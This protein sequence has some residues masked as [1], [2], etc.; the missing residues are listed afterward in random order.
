MNAA[1]SYWLSDYGTGHAWLKWPVRALSF[2]IFFVGWELV[3]RSEQYFAIVPVSET[4]DAL[5]TD[6]GEIWSAMLGTLRIAATGFVPA[7]VLGVLAGTL[8]GTSRI[9]RVALDPLVNVGVV[10]PMTMLVPVLGIYIGLGYRGKVTLV[11]L[12]SLF[13]IIINTAAGVAETPPALRETAHS[14]GIRGVALYRKVI[15]PGALPYVL[16]G[17]R[18][19]AGRA[20]QG[21]IIADLLLEVSHIGLYL[22]R[23][24]STF[25]MPALLAGTL[26]TVTVASAV[27]LL[28]RWAERRALRWLRP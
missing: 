12:F 4:F 18:L 23:A 26:F 6:R 19:G 15:L 16:T 21:A 7:A 8:I 27:M 14:F 3:G 13:V 2:A 1:S 25:D 17:L 5:W 10:A 11:L 9:G 28:A 20:V 22:I 24:G